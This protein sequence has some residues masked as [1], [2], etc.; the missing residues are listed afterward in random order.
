VP[1]PAPGRYDAYYYMYKTN[2]MKN[3]NRFNAEY[4]FRVEYDDDVD[5]VGVS[6]ERAE[7]GWELLGTYFFGGDT[8]RI[9]LSN[10]C[11]LRLVTADAVKIVRKD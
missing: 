7:E 10:E 4:R 6:I 1:V 9:T 2:E 8:V 3:N 11:R 5:N